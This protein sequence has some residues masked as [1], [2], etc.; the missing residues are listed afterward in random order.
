MNDHA[1]AI[2]HLEKMFN[3]AGWAN[4]GWDLELAHF[5]SDLMFFL[6]TGADSEILLHNSNKIRDVFFG[7]KSYMMPNGM[8]GPHTIVGRYC[9]ISKNVFLGNSNH[10]MSNLSTGNA[11]WLNRKPGTEVGYTVIGSDVWI[12]ANAIILQGR[13]IGHGAII[14]A[15]AVVTKDVPPY[16]IVFGYGTITA[17]NCVGAQHA[18]V[19]GNPGVVSGY[20]FAPEIIEGLLETKWW[21]LPEN[22]IERLPQENVEACVETLKLIRNK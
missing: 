17:Y 1:K 10:P 9:S 18:I 14:G 8:L 11:P 7:R 6:E 2:M 13:Q 22:V 4:D 21:M 5:N 19:V 20:R 15:G 3:A 16:A 12:G